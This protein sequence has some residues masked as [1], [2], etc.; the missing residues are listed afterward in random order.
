MKMILFCAPLESVVGKDRFII[1]LHVK[2]F[3]WTRRS[4]PRASA[5]QAEA[6]LTTEP[7]N[8][9]NEQY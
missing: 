6:H 3:C 7:G 1:N 5:H 2:M 8:Q 4:N 9:E